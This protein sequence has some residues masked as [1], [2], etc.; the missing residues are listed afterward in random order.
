M[1]RGLLIAGAL[2]LAA[3]AVFHMKGLQSVSGWVEG[4]RGTIVILLWSN[5]AISWLVVALIWIAAAV[6]P[7][8]ALKLPIWISVL[9]PLAV[10]LPLLAVVDASHPGSYMLLLSAAL[11]AAGAWRMR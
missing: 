3:T 7:A 5:A 9:I 10:G 1:A 8:P 6:R 2:L 11:A 4:G